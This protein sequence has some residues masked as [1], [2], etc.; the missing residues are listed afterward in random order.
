MPDYAPNF[1]ARLRVR[2]RAAFANHTQTWRYP[3]VGD[4]AELGSAQVSIETFYTAISTFMFSDWSVLGVSYALRGSDI[5]LPT[6]G[7]AVTGAIDIAGKPAR[8]KATACSFVGRTQQGLRAIIYQYGINKGIGDDADSDDFR[9]NPGEDTTTDGA[10]AALVAA[11][12]NLCGN[13]G[14]AINWY[15]YMNVKYNDYWERKV[16]QGG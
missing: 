12:T 16:R 9:V 6:A 11:G 10:V 13:D 1:T 15:P 3:G 4:G 14:N 2:Y 7:F 5:F 8:I